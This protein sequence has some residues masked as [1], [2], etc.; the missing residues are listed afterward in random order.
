MFLR[1]VQQMKEGSGVPSL[2]PAFCLWP[3]YTRAAGC[4]PA[5]VR[6]L[7]AGEEGKGCLV[8]SSSRKLSSF[9]DCLQKLLSLSKLG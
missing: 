2:H 9:T 5:H 1:A 8:L 7:S 4:V 6:S 3:G